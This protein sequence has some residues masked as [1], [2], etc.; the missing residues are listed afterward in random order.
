MTAKILIVLIYLVSSLVVTGQT[1]SKINN[2]ELKQDDFQKN[3]VVDFLKV[4]Q[5]LRKYY[6]CNFTGKFSQIPNEVKTKLRKSFPNYDFMI[7]EMETFKDPPVK[8][9]KLVLIID[10]SKND[11]AAFIWAF[12]WALPSKSFKNILQNRQVSSSQ[13][14]LK[15]IDPLARLILYTGSGKIGSSTS[16]K[17]KA[18]I[19][20]LLGDEVFRTLELK[21]H[22]NS[23][24]GNLIVKKQ[25]GEILK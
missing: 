12:N 15:I 23:R 18:K 5:E 19:D 20:M 11:V 8:K 14:A 22:D 2:V 25:D 4:D 16:T 21:I 7:A 6:E 17:N 9:E 1:T 13:E 10:T 24:L 3:K